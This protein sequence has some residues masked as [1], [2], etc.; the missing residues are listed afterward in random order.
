[1][2]PSIRRRNSRMHCETGVGNLASNVK[3]ERCAFPA[4]PSHGS[5]STL[6]P[7]CLS[8][9]APPA[10]RDLHTPC[11]RRLDPRSIQTIVRHHIHFEIRN[12]T[13][14]PTR[15]AIA[16]P[17]VTT[18]SGARGCRSTAAPANPVATIGATKATASVI[19]MTIPIPGMPLISRGERR[20]NRNRSHIANQSARQ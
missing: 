4:T 15:A 19:R 20:I 1:M 13:N 14:W 11:N 5:L 8:A 7:P 9:K 17:N 6:V 3:V 18:F 12:R 16:H 10:S 2:T